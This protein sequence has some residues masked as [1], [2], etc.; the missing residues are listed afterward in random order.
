MFDIAESKNDNIGMI[1]TDE[2]R[3][4]QFS[5]KAFPINDISS[6]GRPVAYKNSRIMKLKHRNVAVSVNTISLLQDSARRQ[7]PGSIKRMPQC[8]GEIQ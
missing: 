4:Q 1:Y 2:V 8:F 3:L 6:R 7:F 5:A